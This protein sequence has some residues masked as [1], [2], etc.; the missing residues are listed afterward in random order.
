MGTRRTAWF[1]AGMAAVLAVSSLGWLGP[2]GAYGQAMAAAPSV[3]QTAGTAMEHSLHHIQPGKVL[4]KYKERLPAATRLSMTALRANPYV[5][6]E[7]GEDQSVPEAVA[8]L[9]RNPEVEYVEPVYLFRL[10]DRAATQDAEQEE[11]AA[12][13]EQPPVPAP[14]AGI[15]QG[16]SDGAVQPITSLMPN[17]PLLVKGDQWGYTVTD[18]TYGW[19]RVEESLRDDIKIAVID[20]GVDANHPDLAGSVLPGYNAVNN[21]ADTRDN[22]GHGT[23]VAGIAAALVDNGL[24]IAGSAGGAK[25]LPVQVGQWQGKDYVIPSDALTE[26]IYWAVNAGADII[27]LSLGMDGYSRA[28]SDAIHFALSRNVVVVAAAGNESN[29][30][31]PKEQGNLDNKTPR[32]FSRTTFPANMDGVIA[33]GS[34]TRLN[35][36]S[37]VLSDFSNVVDNLATV[38]PGT[39]IYSTKM[40]GDYAVG[41]GTSFSAPF[42]SGLAALLVAQDRQLTPRDV[43]RIIKDSSAKVPIAHPVYEGLPLDAFYIGG[44]LLHAGRAFTLPRLKVEA[45]KGSTVNGFTDYGV[46]VLALDDRG[47]PLTD[48]TGKVTLQVQHVTRLGGG[49]NTV[50]DMVY[51]KARTNVSGQASDDYY[52]LSLSATGSDFIGSAPVTFLRRPAAPKASLAAGAYVGGQK[53]ELSTDV[54]GATIYYAT[55]EANSWPPA[56]EY[57]GPITVGASTTITAVTVKSGVM[58]EAASFA[59]TIT[60]SGGGGL[61]GGGGFIPPTQPGVAPVKESVLTVKP[62]KDKLLEQLKSGKEKRV[63]IDATSD[64]AVS[65]VEVEVP[66]EVWSKASASETS[67]VIETDQATLTVPA[68]AIALTSATAAVR[69][70]AGLSGVASDKP[71]Y[72]LLASA[73][74]DLQVYAGERTITTFAEPVTA[75]FKYDAAKIADPSKAAVFYYNPA[76][77]RWEYVGGETAHGSAKV[78]LQHFSRYAVME[79]NRTFADIQGHWAQ[80]AIERMAARQIA[81]GM[82]EADFAPEATLTRAQFAA[83]LTRS[84]RIHTGTGDFPFHDVPQ[85]A[86]YREAVSKALAAG[87][88]SGVSD[89]EFAPEQSITREQMAVMLM[90]AYAYARAHDYANGTATGPESTAWD[91]PS[92]FNDGADISRWALEA[93]KRA[94]GNGL[95]EGNP[96]GTFGPRSQATRA[97][98]ITV[99]SRLLDRLDQG[100]L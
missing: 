6:V 51:G 58:S 62:D 34:V 93:V 22:Y 35:D 67:I 65:R 91:T 3:Q 72:A 68:R 60:P 23:M 64:Q 87:L 50:L 27:N 13:P 1:S 5:E 63:T 41:D 24:G 4:V 71:A 17:D 79:W 21:N 54:Q 86:W 28:V 14:G 89:T 80:T 75:E 100:F 45:V 36:G 81:D 48:V 44:G 98:A 76:D 39:G 74:F 84:L 30:W 49:G 46:T 78:Q 94:V 99:L 7:V 47:Q 43:L 96:D 90:N 16:V 10:M 95:L 83:L 70:S 20:S 40:N 92:R 97:Q 19:R 66:G 18:M 85:D 11:G 69:V 26:G 2:G 61:V 59:Y 32:A 53:V 88:V 77:R 31:L 37:F 12:T 38:A 73:V 29:H 9:S 8:E 56:T 33:V 42:V 82:T 25:I 15:D 57:T 52:D 55:S